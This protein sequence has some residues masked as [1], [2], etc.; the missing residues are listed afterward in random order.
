VPP[1]YD[2]T[3]K[4]PNGWKSDA[5]YRLRGSGFL[6]T[7]REPLFEGLKIIAHGKPISQHEGMPVAALHFCQSRIYEPLLTVLP[8][9]SVASLRLVE[10]AGN[11][12]ITDEDKFLART[13]RA[14]E[15]SFSHA[16]RTSVLWHYCGIT[17]AF[18]WHATELRP[19]KP[20]GWK[21]DVPLPEFSGKF[22]RW[23][24]QAKWPGGRGNPLNLPCKSVA[25]GL[26]E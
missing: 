22:R 23:Q 12:L 4:K 13:L 10:G 16:H 25:A 17:V 26:A 6:P 19:Q 11:P 8:A 2:I 24:K 1:S 3:G 20:N 14:N 18:L 21:S 15:T 9:N 7:L 5:A